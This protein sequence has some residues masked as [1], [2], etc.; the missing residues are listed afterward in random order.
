MKVKI[1]G[2]EKIFSGELSLKQLM[3]E[4]KLDSSKV[5]IERNLEIIPC[6]EHSITQL[7]DGDNIEIVQF[8]GGG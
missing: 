1:N 3:D 4:L 7:N 5:A 8:I 2:Q 6:S